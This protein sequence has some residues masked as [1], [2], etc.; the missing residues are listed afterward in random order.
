ML[1]T[2]LLG[3]FMGL[4]DVMIVNVALPAISANLGTTGATLQLVVAGY[5]VAYGMLLIVGA[6][7]GAE[8][9]RRTVYLTGTAV[10]TAASLACGLATVGPELV[11]F[12]CVQGA[13][14]AL[15]VPQIMSVIQSR[16][17]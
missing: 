6:R 17:S 7:L 2:L 8:L 9:G 3:Q 12:R 13:G 14:A 4:V 10:F 1:A 15:M 16:F 5:T 11:A